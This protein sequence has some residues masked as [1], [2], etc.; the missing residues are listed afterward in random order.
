[1]VNW[2][3]LQPSWLPGDWHLYLPAF[4]TAH[5]SRLNRGNLA[6]RET[7]EVTI[8]L[9]IDRLL[10]PVMMHDLITRPMVRAAA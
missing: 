10:S 7:E 5:D 1:M 9:S 2:G 6:P 8:K 4:R 3:S